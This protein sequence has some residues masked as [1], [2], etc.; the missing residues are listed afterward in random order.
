MTRARGRW[1]YFPRHPQAAPRPALL[2]RQT[3]HVHGLLQQPSRAAGSDAAGY[4]TRHAQ[5]EVLRATHLYPTQHIFRQG[6]TPYG[7][8][9]M[10]DYIATTTKTDRKP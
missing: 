3:A 5:G 2:C 6:P 4:I 1:G 9:T 8:Y 10:D 7:E